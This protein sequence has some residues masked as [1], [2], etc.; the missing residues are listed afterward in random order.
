ME[1]WKINIFLLKPDDFSHSS[2]VQWKNVE[3][4]FERQRSYWRYNH[5]SLNHD[6]RKGTLQGTSFHIPAI[7]G[8]SSEHHRLKRTGWDRGY[9]IVSRRRWVFPKIMVPQ[10]GWFIMENPFKMD[11]LGGLP[12][13]LG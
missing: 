1:P 12:L 6:G 5:F 13:F 3:N 7:S 11:D 10:N 9:V 8:R 2:M 4:I